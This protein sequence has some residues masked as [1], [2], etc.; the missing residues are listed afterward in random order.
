MAMIDCVRQCVVGVVNFR[1][2]LPGQ[3]IAPFWQLKR[4]S[5]NSAESHASKKVTQGTSSAVRCPSSS[6]S[7]WPL[8]VPSFPPL[9]PPHL[10]SSLINQAPP[11]TYPS[12]SAFSAAPTTKPCLTS[13]AASHHGTFSCF[14]SSHT[15]LY[16]VPYVTAE[17]TS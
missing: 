6:G 17:Q 2:E 11:S 5:Q 14:S 8:P 9:R 10:T 15:G 13:A 3:P 1:G 4:S 16:V 7:E 12:L